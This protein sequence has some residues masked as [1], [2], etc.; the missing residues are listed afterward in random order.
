MSHLIYELSYLNEIFIEM[1]E[2]VKKQ[3]EKSTF[4]LINHDLDLA[5][6]IVRTEQRVN[7]SEIN[8]EKE[9]ENIIALFQPVATDLRY[10]IAILKSVSELERIGD[11]AEFVANCIL[12]KQEAFDAELMKLFSI[13]K[14]HALV[15]QMYDHVIEAFETKNSERARKV[16][17]LDKEI[18]KLYKQSIKDMKT[19]LGNQNPKAPEI[20]T[21][22]AINARFERNGDLLTNIAEEIIFYIDAEMLKH[23]KKKKETK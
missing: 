15:I 2:L 12:D 14:I 18:N 11:H 19:E 7:A 22:Y 10:V 5:E 17:K 6:E 8:V 9:C 3:L 1:L 4:A 13:E 23:K 21:I 20:L 16:F